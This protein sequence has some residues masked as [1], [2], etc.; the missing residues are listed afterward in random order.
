[1]LPNPTTRIF[2]YANSLNGFETTQPLVQSNAAKYAV[3]LCHR[4]TT[5]GGLLVL[6]HAVVIV[7]TGVYQNLCN[8]RVLFLLIVVSDRPANR[9]CLDKLGPGANYA[10]DFHG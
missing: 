2:T 9:R 8:P 5:W 4:H 10:N 7:L 6:R 1:M 3:P